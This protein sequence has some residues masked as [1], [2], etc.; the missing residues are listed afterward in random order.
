[1]GRKAGTLG[2]Y[3]FLHH[4][5]HDFLA[6]PEDIVD[7]DFLGRAAF[8]I[9]VAVFAAQQLVAVHG[10]VLV[11]EPGLLHA[12]V[13]KG[14]LERGQHLLH[15][16]LVNVAEHARRRHALY[17]QFR[18]FAVFHDG[19]TLFVRG[20]ADEDFA[21][22]LVAAAFV[23][24]FRRARRHVGLVHLG[25]VVEVG[26]VFL[27][28]IEHPELVHLRMVVFD[29][30]DLHAV[31]ELQVVEHA[32]AV[33]HQDF[34]QRSA[35]HE[36]HVL[37]VALGMGAGHPAVDHAER[38]FQRGDA[39]AAVAYRTEMRLA[40][41]FADAVAGHFHQAELADGRRN[42]IRLV[43]AGHLAEFLVHG[44]AVGIGFHV[45]KVDNDNAVHVTQAQLLRDFAAGVDIRFE[46]D[47]AL[48]LAVHLRTRIHV[49]G[50]EGLGLLD[51]Q[52]APARERDLSLQGTGVVVLYLEVFKKAFVAAPELDL[53]QHVR[54]DLPQVVAQRE[55]LVAVVY[56]DIV[57]VLVEIFPDGALRGIGFLVDAGSDSPVLEIV[58]GPRPLFFQ[59]A[60]LLLQVG[61]GGV[62]ALGADDI[63]YVAGLE[64]V[65]E[66]LQLAAFRL[67]AFALRNAD[68]VG[69]GHADKKAA[70]KQQAHRQ[71]GALV[72]G[73]FLCH[74]HHDF[75]AFAQDLL[76]GG[77]VERLVIV[78]V[79]VAVQRCLAVHH[80][81]LVQHA[82]HPEPD[83]D[84]GEL[85]TRNDLLYNT[86][87]YIAKNLVSRH[88]FDDE[89]GEFTILHDG[90]TLLVG[91]LADQNPA[92]TLVRH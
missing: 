67:V 76:D 14:G 31:L 83:I 61:F 68:K 9:V 51:Y 25:K 82:V 27:L 55:I 5:H 36:S 66:P 81:V 8:V 34:Y 7:R 86:L 46:D 33:S 20:L 38:G 69:P 80:V 84:I 65:D 64:A 18:Q 40:G 48:V 2:A 19:D 16:A 41:H 29:E 62:H 17:D 1:M 37:Q 57:R 12:D 21:L 79:E 60:H 30:F 59:A 45:D 10:I 71:H 88:P 35:H 6:F 56:V 42:D 43:A 92:F 4:L 85:R 89:L 47:L 24:A 3:R 75:V 26:N 53:V 50:H 11:Q 70:R 13:D 44:L 77:I 87:I 54:S 63:A 78:I 58:L 49:D 91:S 74:L 28:G 52:V 23:A 32:G 39:S 22:H 90:E 73:R 72:A 15:H